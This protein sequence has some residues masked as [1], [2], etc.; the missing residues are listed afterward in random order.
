M[1]AQI[2]TA[3][4]CSLRSVLCFLHVCVWMYVF[5]TTV[6]QVESTYSCQDL[7]SLGFHCA[8]AITLDY[9]HFHC[10]PEDIIGTQGSLWLV[11]PS[12]NPK[13][14]GKQRRQRP[15]CRAGPLTQLQRHTETW[16]QPSIPDLAIEL[17]SCTVY[18]HLHTSRVFCRRGDGRVHMT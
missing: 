5:F 16:L 11:L 9:H 7:L 10:I 12:G 8:R 14:K 2:D 15:G 17:A 3:A 4:P 1:A 18:I 13:R 6:C